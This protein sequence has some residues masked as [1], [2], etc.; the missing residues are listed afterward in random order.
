M[1]ALTLGLSGF[2]YADLH[3]RAGLTRL[4]T[5]YLRRLAAADPARHTQL[6]ELR[7]GKR[8]SPIETSELLLA[9][10]PLLD[11][12]LGELFAVTKELQALRA[13]TLAH[14][15]VLAFK[16]QSRAARAPEAC[17]ERSDR[18]VRRAGSMAH[19]R[20]Q[21]RRSQRR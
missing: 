21:G 7:A 1:S 4:D 15:P 3:T 2:R 5:E 16:K 19:R 20:A 9:C 13:A 12:V 14:N 6:L 10:A 11:E 18:V 8:F 17:E